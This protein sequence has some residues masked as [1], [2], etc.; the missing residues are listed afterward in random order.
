M[1]RKG[2]LH[3]ALGLSPGPVT[4]WHQLLP[5]Q[6]LPLRLSSLSPGSS[7]C[8]SKFN[9]TPS[10]SGITL[11]AFWLLF[12]FTPFHYETHEMSGSCLLSP[13]LS[14]LIF[15]PTHL[16]SNFFLHCYPWSLYC[17]IQRSPV[18]YFSL[19][20]SHSTNVAD[21]AF[22][23]ICY[24]LGFSTHCPSSFFSYLDGQFFPACFAGYFSCCCG[25]VGTHYSSASGP[26]RPPSSPGFSPGELSQGQ[27]TPISSGFC[28]LLLSLALTWL[29]IWHPTCVQSHCDFLFNSKTCD[30]LCKKKV[31]SSTELVNL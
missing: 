28:S 27:R 6:L 16:L 21:S 12:S 29:S 22:Q 8:P 24:S 18:H 19:W 1:Q 5:P 2:S 26:H 10:L 13:R 15:V 31:I 23:E 9:H 25:P 3:P 7:F 14:R 4:R 30:S 17:K 11:R 20:P